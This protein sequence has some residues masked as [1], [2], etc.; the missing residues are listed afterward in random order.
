MLIL[1]FFFIFGFLYLGLLIVQVVAHLC[2]WLY[3]DWLS[4]RQIRPYSSLNIRCLFLISFLRVIHTK[5]FTT[6]CCF[7]L[8]PSFLAPNGNRRYRSLALVCNFSKTLV[9]AQVITLFHKLGYSM[10][11]LLL[12]A[13][14]TKFYRSRFM[15]D[16]I[17][18]LSVGR[19]VIAL[20]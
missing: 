14:Y 13:K 5:I 16:F 6:A 8:Q 2:A 15:K 10:H 18:I 19:M 3:L 7:E 4:P 1:L 12:R 20:V 17:K 11:Q 9:Y